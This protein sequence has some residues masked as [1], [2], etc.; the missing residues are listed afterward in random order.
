MLIW[1]KKKSWESSSTPLFHLH[2]MYGGPE[3]PLGS[4]FRIY[5]DSDP[6][7]LLP[8]H[9]AGAATSSISHLDS[10]HRPLLLSW[11][12]LIVISTILHEPCAPRNTAGISRF[13]LEENPKSHPWPSSQYLVCP[14]LQPVC[15]PLS[16]FPRPTGLTR[17]LV[18][19][20]LLLRDTLLPEIFQAAFLS[21]FRL[22]IKWHL[23]CLA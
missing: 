5:P 11:H 17:T 4:I 22:L 23:W 19:S 18:L 13:N 14:S 16:H 2:F 20:V 12:P 3:N 10:C 9:R 15:S 8:W 1:I 21:S 6:I 7:S